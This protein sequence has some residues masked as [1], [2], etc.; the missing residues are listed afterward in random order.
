[1]RSFS[2]GIGPRAA[3][4]AAT[5]VAALAAA[6]PAAAVEPE[7]G[8][9]E[10][11]SATCKNPTCTEPFTQAGAHPN[12]GLTLFELNAAGA[13][14]HEVPVGG[15]AKNVRVDVPAGLTVNPQALPY[16]SMAAFTAIELEK[17][18][19]TE[20]TCEP[21]TILGVDHVVVVN[22]LG[23]DVELEGF[24]YNLIQPTGVPA[25]FGAALNLEP[26]LHIPGLYGHTLIEGGVSWHREVGLNKEV[27]PTSGDYHNIFKIND[28]EGPPLLKSTLVFN[29][30]A[31][32]GF[33]TVPTACTGPQ[34]SHI[35]IE[36][37]SVVAT[38]SFTTPVGAT[39]CNEVPFAPPFAPT[40]AVTPSTTQ[41]DLPDGVTVDVKVPQN[42]EATAIDSST[43][44]VSEITLPEGMTLNPAAASG[45]EACSDEQF[46][47][48][49]GRAVACPAGSQ[50]GAVEVE[51]PTLPPG[52]LK[53]A[54]YV[55]APLS[56]SPS[57]GTE[58]RIFIDAES[59]RY[60]VASRLEGRVKVNESTGRLTTI[61]A[62]NPQA[63]FSEFIMKLSNGNHTPLA[64]PLTCGS[65]STTSLLSPYTEGPAAS[66]FSSFTVDFNGKGEAC[67]SSLPFSLKQ[68]TK[69][70]PNLGGSSTS[71]TL[72]ATRSDGQ[73][74]L[75]KVSTTL[76]EGLV[77]K[78]PSVPRCGEPQ[79]R[80]GRCPAASEIGTVRVS[81]GSGPAPYEL[82]G[83]VFLTKPPQPVSVR[84][85]PPAPE[86]PPFGL[87]IVVP[88]TKVGP[89][90][91]G[92]IVT[93]ATITVDPYTARVTVTSTLPTI[94]GGVPLR[95]RTLTVTITHA[96]F[97]INPTNCGPL[98][99]DTT[100][101]STFGA[102]DTV[103][104]PFQVIGCG[105]LPFKPRFS[106]FS[107]ARTSKRFGASLRVLVGQPA[108]DANMKSVA[109]T[110]PKRLPSRLATL[111]LACSAST[112]AA[113]PG[114]CPQG[115]RVGGVS[116][117]T[118]TLPD[119]LTG[120]AYFVSHGGA[121]FPDLDLVLK[122]DGVTVILVGNTNISRKITHTTFRS[123]PDVPIH[124][125]EMRLPTG[126]RSA[127]AAT[128]S[129]CR[130]R[131]FMPTTIVA[132]NGKTIRQRTRIAV[133]GC[134]MRIVGHRVHGRRA[135]IL[136]A[137]PSAGRLSTSGRDLRVVRNRVRKAVGNAKIAVRLSPLGEKLLSM[138]HRLV[139]R[140]RVAF[141]P[142]S[143]FARP[144][145]AFVRLVFRI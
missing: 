22:E 62:E 128:G 90:D 143:G 49:T 88:A 1:M 64:N 53:G 46:G 103:S 137:T 116:V 140:V 114:A 2:A 110:L 130:H 10:F 122:G 83:T 5:A 94:V 7:F 107:N 111:K 113:N 38:K 41:S 17:G 14:G 135:T 99:T 27:I 56:T 127:L 126:P 39:G 89:Y 40:I 12:V 29:G 44:K 112:F 109:V 144:S 42:E 13:P 100:F 82:P 108:G 21:S 16:C 118:P 121:A 57:S 87:S 67:P 31:G 120:P 18:I 105:A 97:M 60:G 124:S 141:R 96:N 131:L 73:Q 33:L 65:A 58:Y 8:V 69:A 4:V 101:T 119:R 75:S 19:F 74:Y 70:V 15:F 30:Q 3:I 52:S 68:E 72:T 115:S 9:K 139:V 25:E 79:A 86:G 23:E 117:T 106:A 145:Q 76:P 63:P 91:Y 104:T 54:V 129:L 51:V 6:S 80:E 123:L 47:K 77:A 50:I 92:K 45:L 59:A 37:T 93:L 125:F 36:S 84:A 28:I 138:R 85:F 142:A 11:V 43:L 61:V 26:L 136:V 134:R 81:I 78:I 98:H 71:F 32:H 48:G 55:G 102:S 66:P 20:S 34:T 35:E 133:S 95:L 132:Q 24:V